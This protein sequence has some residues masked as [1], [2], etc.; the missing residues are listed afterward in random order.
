MGMGKVKE[1]LMPLHGLSMADCLKILNCSM[2][3]IIKDLPVELRE[4]AI[5]NFIDNL[6]KGIARQNEMKASLN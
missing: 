3:C 4:K 5:N 2:A 1:I 6:R